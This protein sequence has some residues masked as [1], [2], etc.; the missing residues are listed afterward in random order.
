[1][2]PA[3]HANVRSMV[4]RREFMKVGAAGLAF[5][6]FARRAGE[7]RRRLRRAQPRE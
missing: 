4:S 2:R 5:A 1:M 6:A 7:F 3:D